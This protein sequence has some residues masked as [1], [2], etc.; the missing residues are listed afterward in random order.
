MKEK[1]KK[2]R[3]LTVVD[4]KIVAFQVRLQGEVETVDVLHDLEIGIDIDRELDRHPSL[5]AWYVHLAE[6]ASDQKRR[7]ENALE[8]TTEDVWKD[9]E[10]DCAKSEGRGP[11]V[12]AKKMMLGRDERVRKARE[13]LLKAQLVAGLLHGYAKVF[14]QR[15]GMLQS[16]TKLRTTEME[17]LDLGTRGKLVSRRAREQQED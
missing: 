15:G 13:K 9:I 16:K 4:K 17:R 14:E 11:S 10:D 3:G 2:K 5:F 1:E 12:E 8:E 7:A 6:L